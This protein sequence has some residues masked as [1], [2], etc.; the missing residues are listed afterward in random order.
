MKTCDRCGIATNTWTM[1]MFN[2]Q[3]ICPVCKEEE[4]NHPRYQEACEADREAIVRGDYNFKGI[5]WTA[6]HSRR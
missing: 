3:E 2:T 4:R 6:P 1:S 5:G